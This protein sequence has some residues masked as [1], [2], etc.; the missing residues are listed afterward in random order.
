MGAKK[1]SP[2]AHQR[3]LQRSHV[4]LGDIELHELIGILTSLQYNILMF[5]HC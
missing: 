4:R 5:I 1:E 3:Q 2:H